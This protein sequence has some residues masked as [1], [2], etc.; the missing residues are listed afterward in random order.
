MACLKRRIK[1]G[2]KSGKPWLLEASVSVVQ[3]V[4]P[5]RT[6]VTKAEFVL[7]IVTLV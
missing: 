5:K 2:S 4:E 7:C 6:V 1:D 3:A